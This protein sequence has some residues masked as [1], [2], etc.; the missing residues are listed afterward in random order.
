MERRFD[1]LETGTTFYQK[2]DPYLE[3]P[4][5]KV[6]PVKIGLECICGNDEWN[7]KNDD[8]AGNTVHFHPDETILIAPEVRAYGSKAKWRTVWGF[9]T[10]TDEDPKTRKDDGRE[11][12]KFLTI[13]DAMLY[14]QTLCKRF[15]F[16]DKL[17]VIR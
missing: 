12:A 16:H 14:A 15:N 10:F 3:H 9:E 4:F 13:S 5:V 8:G 7:A 6:E 11:Y 17:I 1:S 2:S